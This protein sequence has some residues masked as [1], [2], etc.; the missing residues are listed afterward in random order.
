MTSRIPHEVASARML[1]S[2][3]Q[4]LEPYP[5]R[6]K[7]WKC[8]CLK[9]G[10]VRQTYYDTIMRGGSGCRKCIARNIGNRRRLDIKV[11]EKI[12][13]NANLKPVE[14]YVNSA[15]PLLCECLICGNFVAPTLSD[16]KRGAK[17]E[18][19]RRT[20]IDPEFAI[21]LASKAGV[22]PLEDFRSAS[23]SWKCVHI[24]C[25]E[26]VYPHWTTLKKGGSGCMKCRNKKT[27]QVRKIPEAEAIEIMLNN[28][29]V[30]LAPYVDANTKWK[31]Q[32]KS[33]KH[34]VYPRLS[35][36]K[37]GSKCIYCSTKGLDL[38][39]PA[40]IYLISNPIL[41]A[42]KIGIGGMDTRFNRIGQHT[43][44]DWILFRSMNVKSG[45]LA[46]QIEQEVLDYL[47][48]ELGM[49]PFLAAE[50]MPQGGHTETIDS[51][52]IDLITLWNKVL[53]ISKIN[54]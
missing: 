46:L 7:K 43:K 22:R 11:V 8:K 13:K 10:E 35:N 28:N 45:E 20:K 17:C 24:A 15:K 3:M 44:R 29:F 26:I 40:F 51:T 4:P 6:S 54:K 32:C 16:V 52:E 30:T 27:S 37:N 9:C 36:V 21:R 25:G 50:Q 2:G 53:E 12:L 19:C 5:G 49:K 41:Q 33:C 18:Y 14:Q 47:F 23:L 1:K 48:G 42:H 34:I 39:K 38:E 31:S